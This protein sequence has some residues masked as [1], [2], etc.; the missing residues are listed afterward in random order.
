MD[1]DVLVLLLRDLVHVVVDE[2]GVDDRRWFVE[3]GGMRRRRQR[4]VD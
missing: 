2:L 4:G 3:R 1:L